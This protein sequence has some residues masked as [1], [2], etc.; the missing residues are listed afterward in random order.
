MRIG[1]GDCIVDL[2]IVGL[3]GFGTFHQ[4]EY[5]LI[6]AICAP[7]CIFVRHHGTPSMSN[8]H[9]TFDPIGEKFGAP[10]GRSK[11]L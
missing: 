7:I 1:R 9:Q 8:S 11:K 5:K 3:F 6:G 2:K 10:V 4:C